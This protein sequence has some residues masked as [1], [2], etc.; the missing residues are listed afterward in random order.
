MSVPD[1][2]SMCL[3]ED[4]VEVHDELRQPVNAE[5]RSQRVGEYPYYGAT[6][7]VGWI[8]DY[9]MDGEY[10]L[11][12]EDGAPFLDPTK[13][14]AYRVEGKTWVNNHAHVLRGIE[15]LLTNRFLLHALNCTDYR[16][17]ANGTTRLKL[18]Q[19]AMRRIPLSV[20]PLPEQHR[21]VEK[22]EELFSDLDAGVASLE[23]AKANLKRYRASVLKSAVEGRLTEEWRKEHPQTEDGP[24]LLDRIL[25][26]RREKWEK[27]QLAQFKKKGKEPPKNWQ[28]K[29]EEPAAPGTSELAELPAGWVWATVEQV[30]SNDDWAITDGPFGSNLKTEHYTSCGPLVIRLQNIGDGYF[31]RDDAH[32]SDEHFAGLQRHAVVHN[33]IV[34]AMLGEA[35]PRACLVPEEIPPAI[36]KADCV[37]VTVNGTACIPAFLMR[38]LNSQPTRRRSSL[39]I[40]GVGRP[41]MNLQKLRPLPI[42]L[43]PFAEQEQ[44]VALVEER[45]SQIDSAEKTI[46]SE[47]IRAKRLRQSILK[48]AFE[49]KLV[50]QNPNDEPAS[51]LLERITTRGGQEQPKNTTKARKY[52]ALRLKGGRA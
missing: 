28:S 18:T 8:D 51:V 24:I 23:R 31:K 15:G 52:A 46:D 45:L 38:V 37:K 44:I 42:P 4:V 12:G 22:I 2:W 36:V 32:I 33:D 16:E 5:E 50:P 20:P 3:L 40:A 9:L 13:P 21:I 17:F 25:R 49:G 47:L 43:P 7:Q 1:T 34:V 26:E 41:R 19:G 29:Y 11:L 48:T 6:G 14:K 27:D 39:H 35:L 30:A 10:I